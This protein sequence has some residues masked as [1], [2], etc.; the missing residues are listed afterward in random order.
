MKTLFFWAGIGPFSL[1]QHLINGSISHNGSHLLFLSLP[2][3]WNSFLWTGL[4]AQNQAHSIYNLV[5]GMYRTNVLYISYV[6]LFS[7][8][9]QFDMRYLIRV[10]FAIPRA[11]NGCG[12]PRDAMLQLDR[13]PPIIGFG[14]A[15]A[16]LAASGS[17]KVT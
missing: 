1:Y 9:F 10:S 5:H 2:V 12:R 17:R 4:L 14:S 6:S 16:R 13:R 11:V 15:T 3:P 7:G 8:F